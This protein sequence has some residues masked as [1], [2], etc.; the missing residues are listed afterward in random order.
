MASIIGKKSEETDLWRI[1]DKFLDESINSRTRLRQ[2]RESDYFAATQPL[3]GARET[4]N[5]HTFI[6]WWEKN[7]KENYWI[8][9]S[10]SWRTINQNLVDDVTNIIRY[11]TC[12]GIG[13]LTGGALGVDYIATEVIL[14]EGNAKKQLRVSLPINRYAYM[15][16]F[17][18][19][20]IQTHTINRTQHDSLIHQIRYIDENYPDIIFDKSYYNEGKFLK[21][22][23]YTYRENSYHS[24]NGLIAYGCD[25]LI[26]FR[27]N[28][29][30][31][32]KDTVNKIKFMEKPIFVLN[33]QIDKGGGR[34]I[35]DYELI[36]IPNL[37]NHC[38]L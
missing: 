34:V 27:I 33:Y 35:N 13:I 15:E 6:E 23:N 3:S 17:T 16:H 37:R 9:I 30:R 5:L 20:A 2:E 28:N 18:N 11:T 25:G 38:H 29:S 10:G 36:E 7:K 31:G 14:R 4:M 19:S 22:E 12:E 32:V 8:G 26:A 21:A 1:L 24:R